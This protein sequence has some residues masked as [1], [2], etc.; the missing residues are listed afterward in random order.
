MISTQKSSVQGK[1][2]EDSN[3]PNRPTFQ[4]EL[5]LDF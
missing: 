4:P 1:L 2:R 3:W 5:N